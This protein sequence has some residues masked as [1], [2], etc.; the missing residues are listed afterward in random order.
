MYV[1]EEACLLN[2]CDRSVDKEAHCVHT[3][4]LA[5]FRHG[6][7]QTAAL[8]L[9]LCLNTTA[10]GTEGHTLKVK[11][12][13]QKMWILSKKKQFAVHTEWMLRFRTA[14]NIWSPLRTIVLVVYVQ[15][16]IWPRLEMCACLNAREPICVEGRENG[17]ERWR[18]R[19]SFEN[20]ESEVSPHTLFLF[21]GAQ[22]SFHH[23]GSSGN[24][25]DI[26][27]LFVGGFS[28]IE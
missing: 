19:R 4:A 26:M 25:L 9:E 20:K 21:L 24:I 12:K 5:Q 28:F 11:A 22:G 16:R 8:S 6:L 23:Y 7:Q 3:S 13:L 10:K 17:W 27:V 2:I 18:L 15:K 1:S 14:A